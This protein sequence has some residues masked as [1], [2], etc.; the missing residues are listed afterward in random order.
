[1]G[2][3]GAVPSI[4]DGDVSTRRREVIPGDHAFA[5][6]L[7][8]DVDRPYKTYQ[9]VYYAL[10][11]RDPS[12]LGDLRPGVNAYWTFDRIRAVETDLGVRSAFYF[13]DEE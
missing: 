12:H 11:E 7:T 6:C 2:N 1:M 8:H 9:S 13:L 3:R 5:L 4:T 10:R